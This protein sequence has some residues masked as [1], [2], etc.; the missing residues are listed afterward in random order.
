VITRDELE[1]LF[2]TDAF[3]GVTDSL[4]E[5]T[6][7]GVAGLITAHLGEVD[8][9]ALPQSERD[10]IKNAATWL[11]RYKLQ[12]ALPYDEVKDKALK[13]RY[14]KSLQT[15]QRLGDGRLLLSATASALP[16]MTTAQPMSGWDY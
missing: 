14:E 11:A 6:L 4:W 3:N 13:D 12:D 2:G 5:Q 1:E 16:V 7:S 8:M 10:M 9:A 15:L